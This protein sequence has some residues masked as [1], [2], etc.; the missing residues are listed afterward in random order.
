MTCPDFRG[1]NQ[2][3]TTKMTTVNL[4]L[5][6]VEQ[7]ARALRS[8]MIRRTFAGLVARLSFASSSRQT[9]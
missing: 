1:A 3:E 7:R 6:A 5:I 4:D 8:Q 9:A 2:P